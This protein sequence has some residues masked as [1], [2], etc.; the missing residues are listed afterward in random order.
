MQ[1]YSQLVHK[2]FDTEEACLDAEKEFKTALAEKEAKELKL[3]EEKKSRAKEVEDA[4]EA[5]Q[6]A[7]KKYI[8][9][10][11][12]FIK[13]YKQYRMTYS[14]VADYVN[15]IFEHQLKIF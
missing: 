13:D 1:Y 7:E 15:D 11:N 10:R 9:L 8:K 14:S 12:E 4:Y 3:K 5:Y 2:I 6:E